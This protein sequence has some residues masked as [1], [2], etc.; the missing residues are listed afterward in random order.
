MSSAHSFQM[1]MPFSRSHRTLVSPE[2]NQ[3][4]SPMT[5]FRWIFLVVT[6]GKPSAS[7]NLI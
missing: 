2:M 4:S 7:E 5:D 1:V 3:S 6:N